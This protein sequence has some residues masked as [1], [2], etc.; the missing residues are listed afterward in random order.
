MTFVTDW[1]FFLLLIKNT[2]GKSLAACYDMDQGVNSYYG[3]NVYSF[4]LSHPGPPRLRNL[5]KRYC[6]SQSPWILPTQ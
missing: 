5:S 6:P 1:N 2:I 3:S 4:Y